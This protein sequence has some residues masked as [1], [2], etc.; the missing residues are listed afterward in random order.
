LH[1][2]KVAEICEPADSAGSGGPFAYQT[3]TD[4][5]ALKGGME[6]AQRGAGLARAACEQAAGITTG[7]SSLAAWEMLAACD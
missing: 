1:A 5:F 6:Q 2:S 4:G 7:T 3:V